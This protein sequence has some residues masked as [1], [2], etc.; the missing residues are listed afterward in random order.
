[1]QI[2]VTTPRTKF[3][4]V[5]RLATQPGEPNHGPGALVLRLMVAF[6]ERGESR[7]NFFHAGGKEYFLTAS[8]RA[9]RQRINPTPGRSSPALQPAQSHSPADLLLSLKLSLSHSTC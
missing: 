2:N 9:T 6:Y 7:K 3:L 1:M 4:S 5:T 8:P